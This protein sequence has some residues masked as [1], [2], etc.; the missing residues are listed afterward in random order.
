MDKDTAS[1]EVRRNLAVASSP[2]FA[3]VRPEAGL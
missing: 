2:G 1:R 3:R